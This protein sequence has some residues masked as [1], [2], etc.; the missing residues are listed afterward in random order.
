LGRGWGTSFS[1]FGPRIFG[2]LAKPLFPAN[3]ILPIT[4]LSYV[5]FFKIFGIS[6]FAV[7]ATSF[8][9]YLLLLI[10]TFF[11]A[12]KLGGRIAGLLAFLFVAFDNAVFEYAKSGASE[13]ILMTEAVLAF[14]LVSLRK[15]SANLLAIF[16]FFI[17]YLTRPQALIFILGILLYFLLL[18]FKP[19]KAFVYFGG[20]LVAFLVL[21]RLVFAA[22]PTSPFIYSLTARGEH[23][24]ISFSAG[25][26][27][28][29]Y[30]RG[31]E[32]SLGLIAIFKKVFYNLYNLY[33]L[34]PRI[35][36]PYLFVLFV[37]S[38][39]SFK[40]KKK[41]AFSLATLFIL[42][43]LYLGSSL[44]IALFRYVHPG[45]PLLYIASAIFL[46]DF[47]RKMRLKNLFLL[48][49][50][51]L[52]VFKGVGAMFL[53]PRFEKRVYNT[54]KPPVYTMLSWE[55]KEETAPDWVIVTNLDTWGSWYGERRTVWFPLK[56]EMLVD[57]KTGKIPFDAIYLTSYLI[58][59]ENY[60]MGDEW[61]QIFY[62]PENPGNEF[63]KENFELKGI[64][65]VDASETYEK[66][67]A[68]AILLVKK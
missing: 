32:V 29:N 43:S 18:N 36:N 67:E 4:P 17:M 62:N 50:V 11:L 63:I 25:S 16:L 46:V 8:F 26:D 49:F 24:A 7:I 6:D 34:S 39:F 44:T 12:K 35:L 47:A 66:Q 48:V 37:I 40:E 30:L 52:V 31:G 21:D 28:S 13:I 53:D 27:S 56:P 51:V 20:L 64:Y 15:K 41:K 5:L 60:Y 3:G 22:F 2:N 61:R 45:L 1:F 38:L 10:S 65:K 57:P 19:K 54:S 59:D 55:L 14:Y 23:A 33:R 42:I 68:R 9:Y 58:D